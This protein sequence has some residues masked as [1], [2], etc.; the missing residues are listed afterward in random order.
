[1]IVLVRISCSWLLATSVGLAFS[2]IAATAIV[3]LQAVFKAIIMP[4]LGSHSDAMTYVSLVFNRFCLF[5]SFAGG[6]GLV[7]SGSLVG[8]VPLLYVVAVVAKHRIQFIL[9]FIPLQ[10]VVFILIFFV[11]T[12]IFVIASYLTLW[13]VYHELHWTYNGARDGIASYLQFL[14]SD[15]VAVLSQQIVQ[16]SNF[17]SFSSALD[18]FKN[19][20]VIGNITD[21]WADSA[22]SQTASSNSTALPDPSVLIQA[23][24][25]PFASW[26]PESLMMWYGPLLQQLH[27]GVHVR[28]LYSQLSEAYQQLTSY[29]HVTNVISYARSIIMDFSGYSFAFF[30]SILLQSVSH[31]YNAFVFVAIF[32]TSSWY[33]LTAQDDPI[34][35]SLQAFSGML[36]MKPVVKQKLADFLRH[37][38]VRV[39]EVTLAGSAAA[40]LC[41]WLVHSFALSQVKVLPSL[42]AAVF[43]ALQLCPAQ[44]VSLPCIIVS[45]SSLWSSSCQEPISQKAALQLLMLI[46]QL[47]IVLYAQGD[48]NCQIYSSLSHSSSE[49][50]PS[51]PYLLS[52]FVAGGLLT[53]GL[54]GI[55]IGPLFFCVFSAMKIY[56]DFD[57]SEVAENEET[58]HKHYAFPTEYTP[59]PARQ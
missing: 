21:I 15:A 49:T 20:A 4:F 58:V 23:Y 10:S 27:A 45:A 24:L 8:V 2:L 53:F 46:P 39:A 52:L 29:G 41:T 44:I 12:A 18:F 55:I 43:S 25:G 26:V 50:R 56:Y 40:F 47:Y 9:K 19:D 33:F 30:L 14:P 16:W 51:S 17:F 3:L 59:L 28:R 31:V 48:L 5:L 13:N 32:S 54:H 34:A 7:T 42:I 22:H 37:S 11:T 36:N 38:V 1:M 6:L 57:R 35:S